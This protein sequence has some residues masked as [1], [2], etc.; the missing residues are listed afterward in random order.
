MNKQYEMWRD[1]IAEKV[2]DMLAA[3]GVAVQDAEEILDEVRRYIRDYKQLP[4]LL[5]T[6]EWKWQ[7]LNACPAEEEQEEPKKRKIL[8]MPSHSR[9]TVEPPELPEKSQAEILSVPPGD[10]TCPFV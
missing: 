1:Q 10:N 3:E 2:F 8:T 9:T 6:K 7:G 4:Q 5:P